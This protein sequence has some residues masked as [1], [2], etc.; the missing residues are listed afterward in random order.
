VASRRYAQ[1]QL[2]DEW[3][4][5]SADR[6]GFDQLDGAKRILRSTA[7]GGGA[8]LAPQFDARRPA[9]AGPQLGF[10]NRSRVGK[11]KSLAIAMGAALLLAGTQ[12]AHASCAGDAAAVRAECLQSG[13]NPVDCAAE[14]RDDLRECGRFTPVRRMPM[15]T[16]RPGPMPP[17]IPAPKH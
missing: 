6:R 9:P 4:L 8:N 7:P 14:Y 2:A 17:M 16:P 5:L 10:G 3:Q 1:Q 15:P 12:L 13:G 11:M